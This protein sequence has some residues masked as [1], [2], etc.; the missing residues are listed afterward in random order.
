M[1]NKDR[2]TSRT[3]TKKASKLWLIVSV[4]LLLVA[5]GL[6][7]AA[8][9]IPSFSPFYS[10]NIYS[11]WQNTLG[12]FANIFPFSISE[13]LLYTVPGLFVLDLL[14]QIA[15]I[16]VGLRKK[17]SL[18]HINKK[19]S[20]ASG[21]LGLL[22]R[23]IVVLSITAFLYSANCG[24]N[25]YNISFVEK[26]GLASISN[27]DELLVDFCSY[28]VERINESSE[29]IES[30]FNLSN[31]QD[32]VAFYESGIN[33]QRNAADAM[34]K[35]GSIYPSLSGYY[36]HP[37]AILNSRLF[38]NMGVTG[39]YSPFFIEAN[40]N[41]EMTPYNLPFTCCHELSHLKGYM[42][43]G[44]ANFIGW[45]ACMNS[46]SAAFK[47]SAYLMAWVYAG[48]QLYK[49]DMETLD[50]LYDQLPEDAKKELADN[51]KFWN[52]HETKASEVQ[53]KVNDSYLK[54]NGIKEGI[55]SYDQVVGLML[56]WYAVNS[57]GL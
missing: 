5:L 44:E 47:R 8:R 45:L 34:E 24:V 33:L 14:Y 55:R 49:I 30:S 54:G 3:E 22:K 19:S 43:E 23:L 42:N 39:I 27:D 36:P 29:E 6:A 18:S 1:K 16:L 10:S 50:A 57:F 32:Q 21:I 7:L 41:R 17:S 28:L 9:F 35:L 53:D 56:H 51:N 15:R 20:G 46:E 2:Y 4:P 40:Y 37:K 31:P 12:R 52:E 38:S 13:V 48:N 25:Y 26:E 11:I